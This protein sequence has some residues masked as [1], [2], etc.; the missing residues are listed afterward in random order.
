MF[1]R[2]VDDRRV[3]DAHVAP[4]SDG[5][6][7]SDWP[8]AG[9]DPQS[10]SGSPVLNQHGGVRRTPRQSLIVVLPD[11]HVVSPAIVTQRIGS[12][13]GDEAIDVI[14]ACAGQPLNLPVLQREVRD[15]Q[16]LLAPA[17]TSNED[18]RTLAIR[19]APGDIITL[20][21]GTP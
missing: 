17:G 12:V 15:M 11:N 21:G 19:Q 7:A 9:C 4:K 20:I 8:S 5:T 2:R 18:L 1:H 6:G 14:V 10:G 3:Q 16:I 13:A